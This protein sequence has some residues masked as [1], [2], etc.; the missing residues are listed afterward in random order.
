[1]LEDHQLRTKCGVMTRTSVA[2]LIATLAAQA[3]IDVLGQVQKWRRHPNL[4]KLA[5]ERHYAA[6]MLN[7][8]TE[9][10]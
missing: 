7:E 8:T 5:G 1:M 2:A 3:P 4:L 10:I 6:A 9:S